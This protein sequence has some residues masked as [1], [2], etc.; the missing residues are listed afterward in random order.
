MPLPIEDDSKLGR[1]CDRL[2]PIDDES[3]DAIPD[4]SPDVEMLPM[5][6]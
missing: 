3:E 1:L 4:E 2:A 6:P 5:L